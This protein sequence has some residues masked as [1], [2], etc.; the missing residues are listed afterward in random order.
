VIVPA[1]GM[2]GF[3]ENAWVS[4]TLAIGE[5]VRLEIVAPCPRCV[6]TTLPQGDLPKD[7]DVLRTAVRENRMEFMGHLM[8]TVGV[9]AAVREGGVVRLG[10]PVRVI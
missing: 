5:H 6:M 2:T 8:P 9:Y 7:T 4:R 1:D 3:I 10:D